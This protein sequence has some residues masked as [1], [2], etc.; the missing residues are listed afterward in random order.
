MA[1][2]SARSKRRTSDA[3]MPA[4]GAGLIRFFQDSSQ[5]W[6]IGPIWIVSLA[7][8]LMVFVIIAHVGGFN[9]LFG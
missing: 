6:K 5:G 8:A 1:K 3:P 2:R 4:S 7:G 9:W